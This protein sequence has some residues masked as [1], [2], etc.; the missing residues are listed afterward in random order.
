MNGSGD[1]AT[2]FD[3][4][5]AGI[6]AD[7]WLSGRAP[8]RREGAHASW[9]VDLDYLVGKGWTRCLEAGQGR[10]HG[11]KMGI[12]TWCTEVDP[13]GINPYAEAARRRGEM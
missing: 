13:E 4:A 7:D 2:L 8:S 3:Q 12:D 10:S 11:P 5:C 6:E 9:Q 1:V